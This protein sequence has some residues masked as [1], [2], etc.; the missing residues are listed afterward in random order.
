MQ[1][2]IENIKYS[3]EA[4]GDAFREVLKTQHKN[5]QQISTMLDEAV[6]HLISAEESLSI[7]N[8][9]FDDVDREDYAY[10][11]GRA[12]RD[13]E[14]CFESIQATMRTTKMCEKLRMALT[15]MCLM[16]KS[17]IKEIQ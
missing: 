3:V 10:K 11:Y 17:D 15:G 1:S 8:K 16:L 9:H 12:V 7:V 14:S 4:F 5:V 2:K 6:D 13:C